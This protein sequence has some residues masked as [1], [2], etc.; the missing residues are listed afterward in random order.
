M[1]AVRDRLEEILTRLAARAGE[2]LVFIRLYTEAA[3][4]AADA[5]D[6]RRKANI[7]LGPLDGKVVSIKDVFDVAGEPTLAGSIIR[8][9]AAPADQDAVIVR[10]L[11]RAG[12]VILGKTAMTEFAFSAVGTNPHY[13]TPP[14][15]ADPARI[16]GGSSSGAG[17]SVAEGTSDIAIGSDTGGSVRIPAAVNGVVGFKPTAG[18]I[19]LTGCFPLSS[20]LDSIGPLARS[21]AE[22]AVAD[23]IMAGEESTPLLPLP[24]SGLRIGIPQGR[25]LEELEPAVSDAFQRSL[26]ALEAVGARLVDHAIDDLIAEM[27][28]ATKAGSLAGIEAAEIHSDWL[29]DPEKAASVDPHVSG[30][31]ARRL[32]VSA[33]HY[34]RLLRKRGEL[35]ARMDERLALVDVLALPTVPML[36]PLIARH[37]TDD[38]LWNRTDSLLLRNPQ[39]ANQFDLTSISLPIPGTSLPAGLMFFARHGEDHRLLRIAA[40]AM[41]ALSAG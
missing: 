18:R 13:G 38:R 1:Q 9:N 25:L 35:V 20:T 28:A 33:A 15:A 34:I 2:E 17:V 31:L 27:N 32:T 16:P 6:Q 11:R 7:S 29:M 12:A 24:L 22:C 36:A 3:R 5:A 23:A 14:N 21:V 40:A 4:K 10:R 39:V 41:E 19:P 30:P 37:I 26:K 8:R